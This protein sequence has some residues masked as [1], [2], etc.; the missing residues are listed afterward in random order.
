MSNRE[1]I[2]S[3]IYCADSD[4]PLF[5]KK[6]WLFLVD[7]FRVCENLSFLF[8]TLAKKLFVSQVKLYFI[9][10]FKTNNF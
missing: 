2:N 6:A 5:W 10:K 7:P 3:N 4:S 1:E 9:C 8:G